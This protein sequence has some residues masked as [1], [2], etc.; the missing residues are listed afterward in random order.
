MM[1]LSVSTNQEAFDAVARHLSS[2]PERSMMPHGDAC[3]YRGVGG[4]SCAAGA[5][6]EGEI[7]AIYEGQSVSVLPIERGEVNITLL[8]E[9]QYVHDQFCNW[10]DDGFDNIQALEWVA[11]N[12]HLSPAILPTLF[13]EGT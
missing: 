4:A 12:F 13:P 3:A 11:E 2:M 1:K 9:L 10:G 6:I 5:L 8:G 7:P